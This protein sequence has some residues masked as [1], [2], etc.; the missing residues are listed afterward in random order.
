MYTHDLVT[1]DTAVTTT[2]DLITL[3]Y[4][5]TQNWLVTSDRGSNARLWRLD[6]DYVC[7]LP[8]VNR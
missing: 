1:W 2:L 4:W 5:P 6:L 7:Y 3:T 8:I